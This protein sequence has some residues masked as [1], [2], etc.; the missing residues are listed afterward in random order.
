MNDKFFGS[1]RS[2]PILVMVALL[3]YGLS[4]AARQQPDKEGVAVLLAVLTFFCLAGCILALPDVGAA[5]R[6]LW[7]RTVPFK[8]FPQTEETAEE[9]FK[10]T[11]GED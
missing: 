2:I 6:R 4:L 3:C 7:D 1:W 8:N 11:G 5:A 9:A 10:A